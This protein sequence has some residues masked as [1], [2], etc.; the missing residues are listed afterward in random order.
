[1]SINLAELL[2]DSFREFYDAPIEAWA[3]FANSCE[4]IETKAS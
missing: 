1:M 4:I 2:R 3:E